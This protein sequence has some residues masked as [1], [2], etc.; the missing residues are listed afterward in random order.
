MA[1]LAE[2][3]SEYI[4][5][6]YLETFLKCIC[7]GITN[8]APVVRNAALFALGQF[9][10]HLQ[11]EISRYADE[12]LPILFQYLSQISNQIQQKEIDLPSVDR[13]FYALEIFA[14][15]LNEGLL[16]YLPTLMIILF[17][18]LLD[19]NSPVHICELA[20][21]AIGAAANASKEHMLPYFKQIINIL[22]PYLIT[23]KQTVENMCLLIQAVGKVK[24]HINIKNN[25]KF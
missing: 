15:N 12:L 1:V 24:F 3:C 17:D 8:L 9:S 6:K 16:P 4:R 23:E 5:N 19:N 14:E 21:S 13:M 20:L 11:P 18:I 25:I 7:E 2:G 22:L 10:E